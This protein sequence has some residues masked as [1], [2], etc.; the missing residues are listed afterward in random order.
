MVKDKQK[1]TGKV[2]I[3]DKRQKNLAG[4]DNTGKE[5]RCAEMRMVK[6]QRGTIIRRHEDGTMIKFGRD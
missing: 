1:E 2:C 3:L 5:A 6:K 4:E